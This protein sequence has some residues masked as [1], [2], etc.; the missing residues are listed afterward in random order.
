MGVS[1]VSLPICHCRELSNNSP[2]AFTMPP[3]LR[4]CTAQKITQVLLLSPL[5]Q[6][7][8]VGEA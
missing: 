8:I 5:S 3:P 1:C 6:F 2:V 4:C 7:T